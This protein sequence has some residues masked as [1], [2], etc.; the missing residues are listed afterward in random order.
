VRQRL[1][2]QITADVQREDGSLPLIQ[3][4]PEWEK[5]FAAHQLDTERGT[6]DVA[7]PPELFSKLANG[8]LDKIN[9]ASETG[10]FP[11][12]IT[13]TMRRRF[14]RTVLAAKGLTTPVLSYDE[15]SVD[16][17]P[18]IVGQVNA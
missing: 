2:F 7:L 12:I 18:A 14:L 1:G 3:L 9:R 4:A 10:V 15:L 5:T 11:A 16:A 8:L 17:H 13:S 6:R